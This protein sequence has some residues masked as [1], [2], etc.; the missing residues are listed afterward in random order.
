MSTSKFTLERYFAKKYGSQ[1]EKKLIQFIAEYNEFIKQYKKINMIRL[2]YLNN[3]LSEVYPQQISINISEYEKMHRLLIEGFD[4]VSSLF[5]EVSLE[6]Y[7]FNETAKRLGW[8][9]YISDQ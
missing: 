8:I 1:N 3:R 9:T 6:E 7:L 2:D 4:L 5:I